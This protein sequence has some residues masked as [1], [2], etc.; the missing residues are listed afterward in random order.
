MSQVGKRGEDLCKGPPGL[1]VHAM[2]SSASLQ[3]DTADF[4]GNLSAC[5]LAALRIPVHTKPR[6]F[7]SND[8]PLREKK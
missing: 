1:A 4:Q 2:L 5:L 7:A 3:A 8:V 6:R